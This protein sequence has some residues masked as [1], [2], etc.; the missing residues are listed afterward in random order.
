MLLP[1]AAVTFTLMTLSPSTSVT[2]W[3]ASVPASVS[4]MSDESSHSIVAPESFF[5]G[6]TVTSVTVLATDAA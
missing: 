1:S 5:I 6:V 3:P 2:C 4:I